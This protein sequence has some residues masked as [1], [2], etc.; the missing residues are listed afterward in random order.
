[1]KKEYC[2][3]LC[4]LNT[5]I[6]F[7]TLEV[8]S[9]SLVG[10]IDAFQINLI[11]FLIGGLLL[12]IIV[13]IKENA[14]IGKK[15]LAGVVLLGVINVAVS[16]SL[17][18]LSL[19][20]PEA[21]AS[22]VAVIFS[23]NPVFVT[24]FASFLEREKIGL[25]KIT[26]LAAGVLGIMIIFAPDFQ[27]GVPGVKSPLLALAASITFALYTVLGRRLTERIGSLKMNA[28]SF[29]AGS[30]VLLPFIYLSGRPVISFDYAVWPQVLYLG[31]FVTGI[32]YFTYFIGLAVLGSGR[33]SLVFFIKPVLAGIMAAIML[34]E[35]ITVSL[36]AGTLLIIA[37]IF[38]VI[39]M[40]GRK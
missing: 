31:V 20:V 6:L 2:G 30:L 15:D 26:G 3:C 7:S 28:Y 37:G 17:L 4:L 34:H 32:A 22:V 16:M 1:M 27:T 8:V 9:K 10:R 25:Y 33:G 5:I 29:I 18:Q 23:C 14:G 38:I 36:C 19:Y 39:R 24:I 40:G 13:L 11:R 21:K 35:K 12:F